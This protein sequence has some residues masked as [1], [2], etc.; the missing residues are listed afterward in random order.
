VLRLE[1][2]SEAENSSYVVAATVDRYQ[3]VRLEA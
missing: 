2:T 3:F 1:K